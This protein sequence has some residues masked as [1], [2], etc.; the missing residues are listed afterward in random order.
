MSRL[1]WFRDGSRLDWSRVLLVA[2][3]VTVFAAVLVAGAT[4]TAAFGPYNPAWDGTSDLRQDIETEPGTDSELVRDT[5][6]Y[7]AVDPNG[8]TA[9]VIAPEESYSAA[10]AERV[11]QFVEQGGTLVVLENFGASGNELLA[12]VGADARADGVLLRDERHYYRGPTMPVATDVEPHP[13]TGDAEQLTLNYASAV[14]PGEA[15]VL[16]RTSEYAYRDT[17]RDGELTDGDQLGPHPVATVEP[18]GDGQVVAVGDPSIAVNAM[19]G[20]PDNAAFLQGAYADSDRVLIDLSHTEELPPLTA[21]MLTIRETALL[22]VGI[23]ILGIAG[24]AGVAR[25]GVAPIHDRVR[26]PLARRFGRYSSDEA[27]AVDPVADLGDEHRAAVLRERHPDWDDERVQ[28]VIA[29]LN[30]SGSKREDE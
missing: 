12:A 19:V 23:G 2:L 30:R 3:S 13:L 7:D 27:L 4:S 24:I 20:E 16:V 9:F 14:E 5:E 15:T 6:R 25:F 8:T 11:R 18:V 10:D 29:A 22:Q 21:A 28:R 1:E 26:R 17:N